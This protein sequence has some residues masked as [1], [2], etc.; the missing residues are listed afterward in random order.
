VTQHPTITPRLL[1]RR[2]AA[3]YCGLS[4]P[5]FASVCP[6]APIAFNKSKKLQRYDMRALDRWIDGLAQNDNVGDSDWLARFDQD[7]DR[8]RQGH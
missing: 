7:D 4:A 5:T 3:A 8:A 6:V 2:Q 1:T